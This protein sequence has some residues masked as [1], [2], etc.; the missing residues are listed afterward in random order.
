MGAGR[1]ITA[2][3]VLLHYVEGYEKKI[4]ESNRVVPF[5]DVCHLGTGVSGFFA[6]KKATKPR[7]QMAPKRLLDTI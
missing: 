5:G 3:N 4:S 2:Y 6:S 7:P 1:W